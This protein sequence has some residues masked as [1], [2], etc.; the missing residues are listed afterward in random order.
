MGDLNLHMGIDEAGRGPV[1]GPMVVSGVVM[2]GASR[3][4]LKDIGVKDSKKL[5]PKLRRLFFEHINDEAYWYKI[6]VVWPDTIDEF[7]YKRALNHLECDLMAEIIDSFSGSASVYVDSPQDPRKFEAM[8]RS[9]IRKS[10]VELNCEFKADDIYPIVSAAGI[11]AK[12]SRDMI[13]DELRAEF[14][15][16]GSGY[17]ADPKTKEFIANFTEKHYPYFVRK[18]WKTVSDKQESLF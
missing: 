18:S 10:G 12:V 17:P 13:M 7:V 9:R 15:D 6:A 5:S 2:D 11:L 8:L 1:L 4:L 3:S 14:G 16:F